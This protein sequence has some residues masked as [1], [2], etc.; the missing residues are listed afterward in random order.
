M[1]IPFRVEH[2]LLF[3]NLPESSSHHQTLFYL[4]KS[5]DF[6][7]D[8]DVIQFYIEIIHFRQWKIHSFIVNYRILLGI[9]FYVEEKYAKVTP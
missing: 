7:L 2:F 3:P 8:S 4:L 1:L 9:L 5:V 6:T